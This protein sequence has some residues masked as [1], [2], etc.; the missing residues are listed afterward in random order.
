MENMFTCI[1]NH[2]SWPIVL[3]NFF[4]GYMF[5]DLYRETLVFQDLKERLGQK[6]NL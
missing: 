4:N 6:E 3:V 5:L 1:F 2:F